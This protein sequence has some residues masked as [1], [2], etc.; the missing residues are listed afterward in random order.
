MYE[1]LMRG[2]SVLHLQLTVQALDPIS[3]GVQPG[4]ALRGALYQALAQHFCSERDGS[5]TPGHQDRCPVCWLLAAEDE[6]NLRGRNI[7]RPLTIQP[8]EKSHFL[9]GESFTFGIGL[10]GAARDVLVYL[11]RAV[12]TMGNNGMG[13]GRGRFKLVAI[14]E[15]SPLQDATRMLLSGNQ[16]AIPTLEVT[17]PRILEMT[18]RGDKARLTLR[19]ESPL[20]LIAD[21]Q[22][23]KTPYPQV[24]I[25][26]LLERCQSLAEHYAETDT[27]PNRDDWRAAWEA[28]SGLAA[29]WRIA[30]NDTVWVE[31]WSSSSRTGHITPIGGLVGT[32]RWEGDIAP[33]RSWLL[34]GQSLHVGKDVVKGN[35]WYRVLS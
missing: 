5:Q 14:S 6:N 1:D 28:A 31:G 34:W 33:L 24:F 16:V 18:E 30:H 9:A 22:L 29:T 20:R 7:P 35:G 4:T 10:I 25:M 3:F 26:R 21:G 32:V 17:P 19:L 15:Y 2:L 11:L 13:K 27:P 23:M 12:R 8:P